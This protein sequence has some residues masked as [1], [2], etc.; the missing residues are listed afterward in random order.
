MPQRFLSQHTQ[1]HYGPLHQFNSAKL[2]S[3][4]PPLENSLDT[5]GP[6]PLHLM[7]LPHPWP[8]PQPISAHFVG[9]SYQIQGQDGRKQT[10]GPSEGLH[11]RRGSA[12]PSRATLHLE[13][14]KSPRRPRQPR[15]LAFQP[16]V[17]HVC[18]ASSPLACCNLRSECKEFG[19]SP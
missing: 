7:G 14:N 17:K 9:L 4:S 6:S 12:R 2:C 11:P 8:P 10:R 3:A 15:A 16:V 18:L 1:C 19:R 13:P 5:F